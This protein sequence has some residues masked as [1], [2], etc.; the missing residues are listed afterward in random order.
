MPHTTLRVFHLLSLH[1]LLV[2]SP[3][4]VVSLF[5]IVTKWSESKRHKISP[6]LIFINAIC[7]FCSH[8]RE[9]L[10]K[11]PIYCS[12]L[13][14]YVLRQGKERRGRGGGERSDHFP[15]RDE[16]FSCYLLIFNYSI[17]RT[18]LASIK[19]FSEA[20]LR[21]K[22]EQ[23]ST[24]GAHVANSFAGECGGTAV[25][26]RGWNFL[27]A[28][29]HIKQEERKERAQHTHV[30]SVHAISSHSDPFS[31]RGPRSEV[32]NIAAWPGFQTWPKHTYS[33]SCLMNFW[34][35]H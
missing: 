12:Y 11:L 1:Y 10:F 19:W 26:F 9:N 22:Q 5:S 13:V 2:L 32:F 3:L 4:H 23:M 34:K 15:L 8:I 35:Q 29:K 18:I 25:N 6:A 31:P 16:W 30:P 20:K 33:R 17:S 28:Q 14:R 21:V 7:G 24:F 27:V